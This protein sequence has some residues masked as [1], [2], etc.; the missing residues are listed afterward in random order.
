MP[1]KCAKAI[2]ATFCSTIAEAL[3][4]IF[5]P[6]FPS[7][8]ISPQSTYFS[9]M[10]I[11]KLLIEEASRRP[12]PPPQQSTSK[13]GANS[14]FA[15]RPPKPSVYPPWSAIV[16]ATPQTKMQTI[17]GSHTTYQTAAVNSWRQHAASRAESQNG[18]KVSKAGTIR[19]TSDAVSAAPSNNTERS[20]P[21]VRKP[22]IPPFRRSNAVLSTAEFCETSPK[23]RKRQKL[24]PRFSW[25]VVYDDHAG[26]R[27]PRR[28]T[29]PKSGLSKRVECQGL[30]VWKRRGA[31]YSAASTLVKMGSR[32]NSSISPSE[33]RNSI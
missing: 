32:R 8:C 26:A 12:L 31:E 6:E 22:E 33:R 23:S 11:N 14:I 19:Q 1:Y 28:T 25:H 17:N 20:F 15:Q 13:N 24:S 3:I 16:A 27:E 7:Q 21:A 9:S 29:L 5:G 2:C 10:I 4:P 18:L 30:E